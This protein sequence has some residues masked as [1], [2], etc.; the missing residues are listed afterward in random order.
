MTMP[1]LE[2]EPV[3]RLTRD[4]KD[5]ARLLQVDEVR[6]I[7][8]GY[9]QLQ[10]YRK[11]SENQIR[12]VAESRE[13]AR[14]LEWLAAQARTLETQIKRA[15]DEWTMAQRVG[16]W[17]Q[18]IT[19][20]GPVLSAGLMAHI[21]I[22]K[23]PTAGHIWRFAGFDPTVT[24]GKGEKRPWN[25]DL[26]TLCWKVGQSFMKFQNHPD[27]FYGQFYVDRKALEVAANEAG[28]YQEQAAQALERKR[29]KQITI[30]YQSYSAGKL[31]PAH[32]DARARRWVVKLFLSHLQA[33]M[34]ED[35]YGVPPPKP[36]AIAQLGHGHYIAIPNWPCE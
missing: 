6:Y 2:L 27:D 30:A 34:W 8:D 31:P 24:W 1:I 12:S 28:N 23:A 18:S 19:G 36:F 13:P 21:D 15:M 25:A 5:A 35:R 17:L 29:I 10:E 20:I 9:Y 11:A 14:L 33:V 4:L 32:I 3:A 7:V 26:K 16:R 22:E